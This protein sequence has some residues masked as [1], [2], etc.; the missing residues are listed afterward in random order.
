M[1]VGRGEKLIFLYSPRFNC[2]L[3]T[4]V[5][6]HSLFSVPW[7]DILPLIQNSVRNVLLLRSEITLI[8]RIESVYNCIILSC[9]LQMKGSV[10][11]FKCVGVIHKSNDDKKKFFRFGK[12]NLFRV[13]R[14]YLAIWIPNADPDQIQQHI[15]HNTNVM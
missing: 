7:R 5:V 15:E 12:K 2:F 9:S 13:L 11:T 14:C 10:R 4:F 8:L 3:S 6:Q 1:G